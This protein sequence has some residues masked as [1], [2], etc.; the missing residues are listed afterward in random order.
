MEEARLIHL[1]RGLPRET[2]HGGFTARVLQRLDEPERSAAI[3]WRRH[4]SR[5]VSWN[6]MMVATATMGALGVS[7]GLSVGLLQHDRA[8]MSA[9]S[10]MSQAS[11][12][13]LAASLGPL[14]PSPAPR[15]GRIPAADRA[16][17]QARTAA[18]RQALMVTS[19]DRTFRHE[20]AAGEQPALG[21]GPR[22]ASNRPGGALD[23][24]QAHQMWREL[25][26]ESGRLERE[27][28]SLRQPGRGRPGAVLYLGGDDNV[29]LVLN[30]G[31]ARS[32]G[33]SA[34]ERDDGEDLDYL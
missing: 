32:A 12:A 19:M 13:A 31:R 24:A 11:P 21:I 27:L 30:T 17:Q 7:V 2:A 33:P 4:Q 6:R 25:Q 29:D 8:P 5:S 3:R 34:G 10:P 15:D 28:G 20:G 1:L 9:L 18:G 26:L 14:A 16:S 22:P 23:A